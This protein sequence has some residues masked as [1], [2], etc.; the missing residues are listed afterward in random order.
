[1]TGFRPHPDVLTRRVGDDVVLVHLA[2]NEIFSLNA[3]GSRLWDLLVAGRSRDEAVAQLQAE[4][5]V[6]PETVERE[7]D[8]LVALLER[9]GLATLDR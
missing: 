9:E 1:V 8:E 7:T 5:E 3:T 6:S 4:F 2:R